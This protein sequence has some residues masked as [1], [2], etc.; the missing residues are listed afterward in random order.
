MVAA[1]QPGA[2]LGPI[3]HVISFM[4]NWPPWVFHSAHA[5]TLSN[6]HILPSLAILANS[7][8]PNPQAFIFDFGTWGVIL[9]SRGLQAPLAI[10]LGYRATPF[11]N[12]VLGHLGPLWLLRSAF[13]GPK[14]DQKPHGHHFGRKSRRTQFWPWTNSSTMASGNHQRSP[15]QL[16]P[17]FP[18]TSGDFFLSSI[19][20]VLKVAGIVH[21]W[22]YIPL[23]TIFAQ[24]SNDDVL[25]TQFH[26]SKSRSQ[27]PTPISKED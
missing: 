3:G 23:C 5:I 14:S 16:S 1:I 20:S 7:H 21:I 26:L 8:F 22:Y 18:S 4:A 2:K 19:P 6:G 13:L 11:I 9:F 17:P 25:R 24:Q 10:I 15:D 27:I 12:G